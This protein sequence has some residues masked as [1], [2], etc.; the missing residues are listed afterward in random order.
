MPARLIPDVNKSPSEYF[1]NPSCKNSYL[2]PVTP[3]EIENEI[4]NLK[5]DEATR[6]YSILVNILKLLKSV[7]SVP[8]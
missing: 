4:S 8:L 5:F 1:K 7:I 2:F 3:V 6:P